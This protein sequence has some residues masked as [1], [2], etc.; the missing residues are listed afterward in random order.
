MKINLKNIS[1]VLIIIIFGMGF[2]INTFA[3][4]DDA[5]K[6]L[7][8]LQDIDLLSNKLLPNDELS[9]G[10]F[11][12]IVDKMI[13]FYDNF[14]SG[15]NTSY[16]EDVPVGS[17]NYNA[18]TKLKQRGI[19]SGA[20]NLYLPDESI[21]V[22]QTI[23]VMVTVLGYESFSNDM[24]GYPSGY[25]AVSL[26]LGLL[27]NI[28]KGFKDFIT[29]SD[30]AEI[31][32][33]TI[34]TKM[35]DQFKEKI[36]ESTILKDY[37]DITSQTGIILGTY[38]VNLTNRNVGRNRILIEQTMYD[39]DKNFDNFVGY[40]VEYFM[41]KD[42]MKN[43]SQVIAIRPSSN[44]EELIIDG[45]L[46]KKDNNYEKITY[47]N[48]NGE[49]EEVEINIPFSVINGT[50]KEEFI[51]SDM[52]PTNGRI[53][54]LDNNGDGVYD[55]VFVQSLE[56]I[57]VS[58]LTNEII[59]D[60]YGKPNI[61]ISPDRDKDII[62]YKDGVVAKRTDIEKNNV[63]SVE[64]GEN[65]TYIYISSRVEIGEISEKTADKD[66]VYYVVNGFPYG[67][68][69]SYANYSLNTINE[70]QVGQQGTFFI[71][72]LSQ[73]VAMEENI[74]LDTEITFNLKQY[75]YVMGIGNSGGL[76]GYSIKLLTENNGIQT[77]KLSN[78]I[79]FDGVLTEAGD[80]YNAVNLFIEPETIKESLYKR[81]ITYKINSD[82]RIH[83]INTV[84]KNDGTLK[85]NYD[86]P[87]LFDTYTGTRKLAI[88]PGANG[89][90]N[91]Y[92]ANNQTAI[93][94]I[95]TSGKESEYF[96]TSYNK[97][98]SNREGHGRELHI[99]DVDD[100][101]ATRLVLDVTGEAGS[102]A[103]NS[104]AP[105]YVVESVLTT[106]ID[107][108]IGL[109]ITGYENNLKKT[110]LVR[111]EKLIDKIRN[112]DEIV[113]GDVIRI[114]TVGDY[115]IDYELR[116]VY[117][118]KEFVISK[119]N[120]ESWGNDYWI[121]GRIE[122]Y[123]EKYIKIAVGLNKDDQGISSIGRKINPK[124]GKYVAVPYV[125]YGAPTQ[126]VEVDMNT[127]KMK[128]IKTNEMKV[129]DFVFI[130]S[131]NGAYC[132]AVVIFK[133]PDGYF[134]DNFIMD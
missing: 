66:E 28:E 110:Y 82:K 5:S 31:V 73:I 94:V 80:V 92:F 62:F 59:S 99:F 21:T 41:R 131:Q 76:D 97:F 86:T 50:R 29:V 98:Y 26:Q 48:T 108:E 69:K 42:K 38:Y 85:N 81:V 107:D 13:D 52:Y 71:D 57:V 133:M 72:I 49:D 125:S 2:C 67:V 101:F 114:F 32:Y 43:N 34:R 23:K 56:N 55:Y 20:G 8:F 37:M 68:D 45:H 79:R 54:L 75:G 61:D 124:Y 134:N 96:S 84:I 9:R 118:K 51:P 91:Y 63:L 88:R 119:N 130:F 90:S 83:N 44:N 18:I 33:N 65:Y 128:L 30:F 104:G 4:T 6:N 121:F 53:K 22:E 113:F 60:R 7:T 77:F 27:K 14:A 78:K 132:K 89:F 11:A 47:E 35:Y 126:F 117:P 100:M 64:K 12:T 15:T 87:V 127:K 16:F 39:C 102:V 70:L 10:E 123:N 46:I 112:S 93:F 58:R 3:A 36:T 19:I 129:N 109:K 120:E 95:P 116:R 17:P 103:D 40:N 105:M 106:L 122:N 25:I 115:L 1:L 111:N 24:G 74:N